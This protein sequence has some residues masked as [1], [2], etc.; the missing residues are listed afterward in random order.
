MRKTISIGTKKKVLM[1]VFVRPN[2]YYFEDKTFILFLDPKNL[3]PS[4]EVWLASLRLE[5]Y[6][7][8]F[9]SHGYQTMEQVQ[10]IL[11]DLQLR[12]VSFFPAV[13]ILSLYCGT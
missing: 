10:S 6:L 12:T 2:L 3:P 11:W 5:A 7:E 1:K 13:I 9:L 4:V 8:N